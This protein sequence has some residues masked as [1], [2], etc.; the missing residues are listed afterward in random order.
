MRRRRE[1]GTAIRDR[2]SITS[3]PETFAKVYAEDRWH[4]LLRGRRA[5]R[6]LGLIPAGYTC[7]ASSGAITSP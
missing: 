5:Y 3:A 4:P 1:G 6:L 7:G 2:E